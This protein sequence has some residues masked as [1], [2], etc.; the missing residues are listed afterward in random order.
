MSRCRLPWVTAGCVQGTVGTGRSGGK[1]HVSARCWGCET[2]A[3]GA[4]AGWDGR[5][6]GA[7]LCVGE[8]TVFPQSFRTCEVQS[9]TDEQQ[10]GMEWGWGCGEGGLIPLLPKEQSQE[11]NQ[12]KPG[13]PVR[14]SKEGCKP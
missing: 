11:G 3:G 5:R 12:W 1:T 10:P 8:A 2:G 6:D 7:W 14:A 9:N 4:Q 13:W